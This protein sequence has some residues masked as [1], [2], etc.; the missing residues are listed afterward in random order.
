MAVGCPF[1]PFSCFPFAFLEV[2]EIYHWFNQED[3]EGLHM[4]MTWSWTKSR[5]GVHRQ[6]AMCLCTGLLLITNR[7]PTLG[8]SQ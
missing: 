7:L 2:T 1:P 8:I 4:P 6:K 5:G 3:Q